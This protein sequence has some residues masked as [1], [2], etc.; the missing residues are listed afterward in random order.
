M[1]LKRLLDFLREERVYR[2]LL[3]Q[4][5]AARGLSL[6]R[7]G[8]RALIVPCDPW[9]VV[10]SRGDQAMIMA[11][12]QHLRATNPSIEVDILTDSND[13]D[14]AVRALGMNPRAEWNVPFDRWMAEHAVDYREVIIVGADVTDGVYGFP[15]AMKMLMFYDIFSRIGVATR[16]LGFSW[17]RTPH[18]MMKRVLRFLTPGLPL[19]VRDPVSLKRLES[20]TKHS[21]LVQVADAA[22]CLKPNLTPRA[23]EVSDWCTAE[24]A[25]GKKVVA[26]NVHPMFNDV[27]AKGAEWNAAFVRA[28][29]RLLEKHANLSLLFLPHDNRPRV[30]DQKL[31][32]SLY[33]AMPS[34][35][36]ARIRFVDEVMNADEIKAVLGFV[37]GLIAGRMH[38]SIAALGQGVP[39]FALVYQGKFEGLWQHFGLSNDTMTLPGLFL[40]DASSV[41]VKLSEYI[42]SLDRQAAQIKDRLVRV[43]ALSKM[44]F[45]ERG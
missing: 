20:F 37:D 19:P 27:D 22:F 3:G 28:L 24:R 12:L 44:N 29:T 1:V 11:T 25:S 41:N 2:L 17:S 39:V 15:T 4:W 14:E 33:E 13:T 38:I 10:G 16:Y 36:A 6:E 31:L 18:R 21:P 45:K 35:C 9:S 23:K 43:I 42:T 5:K 7:A 32:K 40:E 8:A 26:I 30:S 34:E